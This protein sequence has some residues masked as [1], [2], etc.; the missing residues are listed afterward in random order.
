MAE[1]KMEKGFRLFRYDGKLFRKK[2]GGLPGAVD[3]VKVGE[4]WLPHKGDRLA[5]MHY[6]EE[7]TGG[8]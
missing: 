5:P 4:K 8:A 3:E 2:P 1:E 7:V 6:G